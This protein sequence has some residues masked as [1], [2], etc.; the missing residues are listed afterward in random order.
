MHFDK[1]LLPLQPQKIQGRSP[2]GLERCSHIAEVIGSNPIVPT[3]WIFYPMEYTIY[4]NVYIIIYKLDIYFQISIMPNN[5]HRQV[6]PIHIGKK[7]FL[8]TWAKESDYKIN[9]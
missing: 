9:T 8:Y 7:R 1:I 6:F 2:A 5:M 3:S 4:N